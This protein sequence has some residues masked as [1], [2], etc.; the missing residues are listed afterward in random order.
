MC[1]MTFLSWSKAV[2]WSDLKRPNTDSSS[3]GIEKYL[4]RE[5]PKQINRTIK[6][7]QNAEVRF[8]KTCNAMRGLLKN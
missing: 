6:T 1:I 7:D 5:R 4:I 2:A 3:F 8:I